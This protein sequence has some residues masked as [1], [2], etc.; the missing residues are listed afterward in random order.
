M[1]EIPK[2]R[3]IVVHCKSGVRSLQAIQLLEKQGFDD[4][5]NL[6]GGILAWQSQ[7]DP[8]MAVY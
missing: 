7:V 3:P 2:N 6:E 1:K 8:D 5:Y 4:L